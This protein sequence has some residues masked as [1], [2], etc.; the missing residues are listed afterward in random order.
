[1]SLYLAFIYK[2]FGYV[3]L[4]ARFVT[5]ILSTVIVGLLYLLTKRLFNYKVALLAA[6]IA[7]L[8]AYLIFY[9]VTLV[10]ETPFI[11][12]IIVAITLAYDLA[13]K[14]NLWKWIGLGMALAISVLFRMAVV[15]YIPF[16]LGWVYFQGK[17][18][19]SYLLIPA[20]MIV[21]AVLPITIR[22]YQLWDRFLLLESQ[23][24]HVFWNGNHPDSQGNFHPFRTYPIPTEV[25]ESGNDAEITNQLFRMGV[26][27]IVNDPNLFLKLTITRLREY[28]KFWPTS[29]STL[30]A[31]L[32]RVISFGI[33]WPFALAGLI[34]SRHKWRSLFPI[35]LF[36]LIHTG[37]YA[38]SWTMI[39]Y[40]IPLD[41]LLIIFAAY[42]LLWA[43]QPLIRLFE[44]RQ[45]T[46]KKGT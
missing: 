22:N 19:A 3:P 29:D 14:P 26:D 42:G 8:Y 6:L 27:N 18:R 39:R 43:A 4:V 23:F 30:Y 35:Y 34:L 16:L 20:T 38:I 2:I 17:M 45:L 31:N 33:M 12:S 32:L 15:F 13:E 46:L 44:K 25:L 5:A 7:A 1:M 10:T 40:R 41:A 36:M 21:L 11:L 28:F 37:V 24:G 9:G